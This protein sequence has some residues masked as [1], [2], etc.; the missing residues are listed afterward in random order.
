[1]NAPSRVCYR[2]MFATDA[3]PLAPVSNPEGRFHHSNQTAL[4]ASATFEGAVVATMTYVRAGDPTRTVFGLEVSGGRLV[5]LTAPDATTQ[6]GIDVT[7]ANRRWQDDRA[8]GRAPATWVLSDALRRNGAD[9]MIYA[10]RK[11]PDLSHL[12]LFRWNMPGAPQ[13]V[14]SGPPRPFPQ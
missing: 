9:G 4:Y 14:L 3:N 6:L 12:V 13:L 7:V 8:A 5:D 1:M 10:S 11:R 2:V